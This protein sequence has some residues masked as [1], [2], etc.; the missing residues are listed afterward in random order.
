MYNVES[1][2][3][4]TTILIIIF[5]HVARW[6]STIVNQGY[7]IKQLTPDLSL[8]LCNVDGKMLRCFWQGD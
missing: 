6:I 4:N 8:S 2:N 3:P 7:I 1:I 5:K